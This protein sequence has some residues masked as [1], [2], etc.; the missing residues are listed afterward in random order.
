MNR[1]ARAIVALS[2][3]LALSACDRKPDDA[4]GQKVRA[5]LL[6]HPEVLE[7]VAVK[8]NEKSPRRSGWRP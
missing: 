6:E 7:E 4:F 5:Y 1:P 3:L 2:A 8:L